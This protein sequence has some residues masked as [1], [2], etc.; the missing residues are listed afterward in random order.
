MGTNEPLRLLVPILSASA[1][2][3]TSQ[4]EIFCSAWHLPFRVILNKI[5]LSDIFFPE[6]VDTCTFIV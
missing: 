1:L 4:G 2:T 3:F 6:A 5:G